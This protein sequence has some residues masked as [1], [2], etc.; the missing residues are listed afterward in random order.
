MNLIPQSAH[1]DLIRAAER[2][3]QL[4][5]GRPMP[6]RSAFNP[7]QFAWVM[8]RMYLLD[9]LD[10]G[11]DYRVRLFGEFWQ[12]VYGID[13]AGH[14]L[15]SLEAEGK[16]TGLRSDYDRLVKAHELSYRPGTVNWPNGQSF[17]YERLL[18][19]FV[20]DWGCVALILVMA[21]CDISTEDLVFFRG[22]GFPALVL[23]EP[24]EPIQ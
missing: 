1:P 16:L 20:D 8:G 24:L 7:T 14:R 5:K 19:P 17:K 9:V 10:E 21:T 3:V 2:Y 11:A 18:L 15:S 4:A 6:A 22:L 23:D 13:L 12:T